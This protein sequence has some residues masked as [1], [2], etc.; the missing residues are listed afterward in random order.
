MSREK[1][2]R[3]R[4]NMLGKASFV[5]VI[6]APTRRGHRRRPGAGRAG[7]CG[8]ARAVYALAPRPRRPACL[9]RCVGSVGQATRSS[10]RAP[11]RRP[12]EGDAAVAQR[13]VGVV[14]DD[15]VVEQ[16]D[17]EQ[18]AGGEGLGRQVQV[19]GRRRRVARRVVVDEDDARRVEPDRV[20]EELADADERGADVA[21]VDGRDA[22]HVVLRVEQHDAQLLALEPAHL[23]DQPVRDVA[24]AADRPA[25]GR[26]VGQQPSAELERGDQLGRTGLA[27]PG[28]ARELEVRGPGEAG[29]AV[30]AGQDV[31]GQ[32]DRGSAARPRS[33]DQREQL[34]GGQTG[35]AAQGQP[36]ARPLGGRELADR[37]ARRTR[38]G[39]PARPPRHLHRVAGTRRSR[40]SPGPDDGS[41]PI[42]PAIRTSRTA[43]R[44][45]RGPHRGLNRRLRRPLTAAAGVRTA[46][47]A[48]DQ[49]DAR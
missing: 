41:P 14:A 10:A 19:V 36:L 2:P 20:A 29:Q 33:P 1:R 25:A 26:P 32:V 28:Q 43:A 40:A 3:M 31:R 47:L 12:V 38:R 4:S 9:R 17:V 7:R 13:H 30:V 24:R 8:K 11:R 39:R 6:A 22:Q 46:Q 34:R 44:L 48:E 45:P 35:R 15:E 21:L 5:G 37:A 16:A 49:Q 27:D 18:P 23:E 42:P